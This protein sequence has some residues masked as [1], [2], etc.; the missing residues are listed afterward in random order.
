MIQLYRQIHSIP[1]SGEGNVLYN[2]I[3]LVQEVIDVVSKELEKQLDDL[4]QKY[5]EKLEREK[6]QN[7]LERF[8]NE[9][10]GENQLAAK[11]AK[12]MLQQGDNMED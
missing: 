4:Q 12:D 9:D 1:L 5:K 8:A 7:V 2:D 10:D 11:I 6:N 3:G